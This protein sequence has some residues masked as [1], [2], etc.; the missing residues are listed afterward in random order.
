MK[1]AASMLG[2]CVIAIFGTTGLGFYFYN[3]Q[4]NID[5]SK[6]TGSNSLNNSS[7]NVTYNINHHHFYATEQSKK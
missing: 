1:K 5:Q 2:A 4:T 7:M 6:I 3:S